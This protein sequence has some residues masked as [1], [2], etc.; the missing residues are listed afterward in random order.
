MKRIWMV[1][2]ANR[3]ASATQRIDIDT[4]CVRRHGARAL[5][6]CSFTHLTRQSA[7]R[8]EIGDEP[9]HI[10]VR[11]MVEQRPRAVRLA[12]R[13]LRRGAARPLIGFGA[14][15]R[16]A[17]GSPRRGRRSGK[18][19]T[20]SSRSVHESFPHPLAHQRG[21]ELGKLLM[22]RVGPAAQIAVL[23]NNKV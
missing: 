15:A 3:A 6:G 14:A 17:D 21:R 11:H 9:I 18:S 20:L 16:A 2:L 19:A 12:R 5:H 22:R 10:M 13:Q 7:L 1:G 23:R 8:R 4:A